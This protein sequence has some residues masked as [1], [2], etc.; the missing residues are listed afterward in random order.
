MEPP[1]CR[2]VVPGRVEQDRVF[3][4]TGERTFSP[5]PSRWKPVS[6]P[7]WQGERTTAPL[8][9]PGRHDQR[10]VM[11]MGL[12]CGP[13]GSRTRSRTRANGREQARDCQ[14]LLEGRTDSLKTSPSNLLFLGRPSSALVDPVFF[15]ALPA[16]GNSFQPIQPCNNGTAVVADGHCPLPRPRAVRNRLR[17][18]VHTHTSIRG[19]VRDSGSAYV[20]PAPRTF[21]KTALDRLWPR[22]EKA[23]THGVS[24]FASFIYARQRP[25]NPFG[26]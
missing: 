23:S 16:D 21:P 3:K 12:E 24:R 22:P 19:Q 17:E 7:S 14:G 1:G 25:E 9:S 13:S 2:Q 26:R 4:S 20:F 10:P 8:A 5:D 6:R 11:G 15:S 18:S